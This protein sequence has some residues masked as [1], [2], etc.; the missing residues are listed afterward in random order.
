MALEPG[1]RIG[2]YDVGSL[3]GEGGMG[4]ARI[5]GSRW[6]T[7]LGV[8]G[9]AAHGLAPALVAFVSEDAGT[10]FPLLVLFA[11]WLLLAGLLGTQ[12]SDEVVAGAG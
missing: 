5:L 11:V 7:W 9:L 4:Q 12:R 3:L 1:S 6:V 10:L 8:V 2:H